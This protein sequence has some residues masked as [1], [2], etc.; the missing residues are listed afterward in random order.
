M[1]DLNSKTLQQYF[2]MI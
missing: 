2:Y 1:T